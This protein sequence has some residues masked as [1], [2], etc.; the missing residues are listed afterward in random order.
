MHGQLVAFL[1]GTMEYPGECA[2]ECDCGDAPCGGY[3]FDHRNA[4]FAEWF[5]HVWVVSNETILRYARNAFSL[6]VPPVV[7]PFQCR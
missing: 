1:A 6:T 5:I 2:A 3:V 4:S 7:S